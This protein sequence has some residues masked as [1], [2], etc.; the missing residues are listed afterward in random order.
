MEIASRG[1]LR[2]QFLRWA[3]VTVPFIVLLGFTS[4]RMAPTGSQNA[5]YVELIKPEQNPPNWVFPVAWTT[6]YVLLGL[7]LAMIINAR[8]SRLRG[9]AIWFFAAQMIANLVWSPLFFG[10]HQVLWSLIDIGLMIALT[11]VTIVLF[12]R[13]RKFA[14]VLLLPYLAW[15]CFAGFLTFEIN[16]LN[17]N[18]QSLVPASSETQ[19]AV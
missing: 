4:G 13:I 3:I 9:P 16:R 18:A 12:F 10:A 6:L 5:W 11:L 2:L 15:I 1:Q 8:G 19:M 14:G 17:P 7:A